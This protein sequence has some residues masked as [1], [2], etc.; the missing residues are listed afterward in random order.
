[1]LKY[2][3][4]IQEL[5]KSIQ[6]PAAVAVTHCKARQ[7]SKSAPGLGNQWAGMAAKG[8]AEKGILTLTPAEE[9]PAGSTAKT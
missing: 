4:Q 9:S 7:A 8:G 1:M 5:L 3:P 2:A 6:K